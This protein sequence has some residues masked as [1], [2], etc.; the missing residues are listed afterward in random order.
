LLATFQKTLRKLSVLQVTSFYLEL[1]LPK[2]LNTC[3]WKVAAAPIHD[4]M[5]LQIAVISG[6]QKNLLAPISLSEKVE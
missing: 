2:G 4:P 5:T 6:K 3:I 1:N